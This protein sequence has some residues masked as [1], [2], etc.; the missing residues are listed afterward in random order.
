MITAEEVYRVE[1]FKVIDSASENLNEYFTSTDLMVYRDLGEMLLSG[2]F[3]PQIVRKYPEL[4]D[5]LEQELGFFR[6]QFS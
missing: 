3:K 1:F 2:S 4:S 5:S 6:N